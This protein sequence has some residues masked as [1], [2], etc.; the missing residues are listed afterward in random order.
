MARGLGAQAEVAGGLDQARAEVV[1]PDAIDQD[2]GGEGVA[3]RGDGSGQFEPPVALS[4]GSAV[5]SGE[6]LDE[7]AWD[8]GP[9]LRRAAAA[10]HHGLRLRG[11]LGEHEGRLRAEG[12]EAAV[13]R[14]L[15]L[16]EFFGDLGRVEV[17]GVHHAG[18]GHGSGRGGVVEEAPKG[19][20]GRIGQGDRV[21]RVGS[22]GLWVDWF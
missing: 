4:E 6:H 3:G 19:L 5:G 15:E 7:T 12:D 11:P 16:P 22:T 18:V 1:L 21:G 17:F 2:A 13:H 9:R 8:L 20:G 10:E 14:A